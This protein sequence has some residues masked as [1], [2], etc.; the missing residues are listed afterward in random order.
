MMIFDSGLL[1]FGHP[2]YIVAC[3]GTYSIFLFILVMRKASYG[4]AVVFLFI[5]LYV[6]VHR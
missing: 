4:T 3:F 1:F 6:T 2:V 5:V